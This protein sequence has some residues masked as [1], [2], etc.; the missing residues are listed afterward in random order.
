MGG[1]VVAE[2][3]TGTV[4]EVGGAE[5]GSTGKEK[6]RKIVI[7]DDPS[8]QYGKTFRVWGNEYAYEILQGKA[9]QVV[10]VEY[11]IDNR[12]GP[13]G[14]YQQNRITDVLQDVGGGGNGFA[15]GEVSGNAPPVSPPPAA[16]DW[17]A[18]KVSGAG[19]PAPAPTSTPPP[20]TPQNKDEYWE[21]RTI[22][23]QQRSLEMEAAWAVKACLDKDPTASNQKLVQDAIGLIMLKRQVASEMAE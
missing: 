17:S 14:P 23:D 19:T 13:Q 1:A 7:K 8:A 16:Q 10:T 9:G 4:V 20:S 6:P 3:Y 2:T 15:G 22:L 5:I 12:Q 18:P 11:V 21:Q